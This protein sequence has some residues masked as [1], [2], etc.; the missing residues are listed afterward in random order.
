M[1]AAFGVTV[2]DVMV[3]PLYVAVTVVAAFSVTL[4]VTV[5]TVVQPAH[6]ANVLLPEVEGAVSVMAI[7]AL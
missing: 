1:I 4:Q 5:L 3:G 7:P 6:E 2:M